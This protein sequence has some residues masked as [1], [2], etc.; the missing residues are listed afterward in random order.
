M[1]NNNHHH[2]AIAVGLTGTCFALGAPLAAYTLA[3][4]AGTAAGGALQAAVGRCALP[5]AVGVLA[6]VVSYAL[7][8]AIADRLNRRR[9]SF[10][11]A[12]SEVPAPQEHLG[13]P[14]YDVGGG[15]GEV[16]SP[17]DAYAPSATY[18]YP[19]DSIAFPAQPDPMVADTFAAAE[20]ASVSFEPRTAH[21]AAAHGAPCQDRRSRIDAAVPRVEDRRP[22]FETSGFADALRDAG[23]T[24]T[25]MFKERRDAGVPQISRAEGALSEE[26]AWAS[27]DDEQSPFSC[28]ASKA[29]DIYQVAFETL[30]ERA[31][32]RAAAESPAAPVSMP[33]LH[34]VSDELLRS[35]KTGST[36]SFAAPSSL[37]DTAAALASL[38]HVPPTAPAADYAAYVAR[39][40]QAVASSHTAASAVQPTTSEQ[41]R[42]IHSIPDLDPV[43]N[44]VLQTSMV[45]ARVEAMCREE[46]SAQQPSRPVPQPNPTVAPESES[47]SQP[48]SFSAP[49][50]GYVPGPTPATYTCAQRDFSGHE[51]TWARALA[52]LEEDEP[53]A[54]A[55]VDTRPYRTQIQ[56]TTTSFR[57]VGE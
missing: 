57:A 20:G 54:S 47:R 38:S 31:A 33:G 23:E 24:L 21:A 10:A 9:A 34:P 7:G 48:S 46:V 45:Q 40:A 3:P 35:V 6:G 27:I 53:V 5:F 25:D 56:G 37:G 30:N 12:G 26:E 49:M 29:Q 13:A 11:E 55:P 16:W 50:P 41:P 36:G 51:D 1:A 18:A 8:S 42:G 52:I 22:R 43:A 17:Q 14:A 32:Q 19:D 28:D 39:P 4:L 2:R 15:A 44:G